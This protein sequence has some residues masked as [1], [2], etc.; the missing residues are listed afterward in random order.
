MAPADQFLQTIVT[1]D[2]EWA[3]HYQPEM[4]IQ[5]KQWNWKHPVSPVP[6]KVRKM[7]SAGEF[8]ATVF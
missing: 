3:H 8:M 5:P 6:K 1:V 4:E 7:K 2:E